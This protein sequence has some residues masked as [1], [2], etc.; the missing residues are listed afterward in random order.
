MVIELRPV[1][2]DVEP[3]VT[4]VFLKA[5]DML[6]GLQKLAEYRTLTWLPSLAR[7]AFAVVLREEYLKTEDEIAELVGLTRQTVRNILRADPEMAIYKVQHLEEL[8]Q[9]EKK[10]LRVH[11]AGGIA[12]LAYKLVK[13]GHEEPRLFLEY[14]TQAALALD[15]PWAYMVLK[16]IKGT[17]FPVQSADDV[18]EKLSGVVIRGR[19]AEEVIQELEYPIKNPAELLHRIKENLKMHGIE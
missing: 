16:R 19:K 17:D 12:K 4:R 18:R 13:E 10:E 5:I 8:T 2:V 14:C 3:L 11:T 15:V 6:G 7:A 9:E 1:E